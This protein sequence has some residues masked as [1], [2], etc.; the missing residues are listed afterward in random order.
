MN[1]AVFLDRDGVINVERGEYT[2][3][4]SDF[5]W[6]DNIKANLKKLSNKGYSLIVITNQGGIAKGIYSLQQVE[7]LHQFIRSELRKSG[8]EIARIYISPHH[9][10]HGKSLDRKPGSLMFERAIYHFNLDPTQCVMIGD[11]DRDIV[12]SKK[13]GIGQNFLINAN[14]SIDNIVEGL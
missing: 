14:E 6:V 3:L 9:E 4:I 8:V 7:E 1:K 10:D 2:Y 5:Q 12:P 13:V 11:S